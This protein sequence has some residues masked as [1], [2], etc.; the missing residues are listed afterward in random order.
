LNLHSAKDGW[1]RTLVRGGMSAALC[2]AGVFAAAA[3]GQAGSAAHH[4]TLVPVTVPSAPSGSW[5]FDGRVNAA[6]IVG[7]TAFVGGEFTHAL[8]PAAAGANTP[9]ART[10]LAAIDLTTGGL[11]GWNPGANGKIWGISASSDGTRVYV[12][13]DFSM[14]GILGRSHIAAFSS[15]N[16][17]LLPWAPRV[18]GRVRPI[19][20]TSSY[21]YIGGNFA[22]VFGIVQPRL[23]R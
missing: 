16:G 17:A 11:L 21:V 23:A 5:Q 10:R 1:H 20:A 18:S 6:V 4:R 22:D 14:I 19:V 9:V 15:A 7:N 8:P 13:G 3:P 2:A 12:G